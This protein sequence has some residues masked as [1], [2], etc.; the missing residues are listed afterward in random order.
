MIES[1]KEAV[2]GITNLD[3]A[4]RFG[5]YLVIV[6]GLKKAVE[7]EHKLTPSPVIA[8]IELALH[9]ASVSIGEHIKNLNKGN[10]DGN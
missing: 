9:D 1:E 8:M 2:A 4:G 3:R 7:H 10:K 6:A 5:E